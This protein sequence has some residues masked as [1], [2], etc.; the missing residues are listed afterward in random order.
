MGTT[1]LGWETC[2]ELERETGEGE[3]GQPELCMKVPQGNWLCNLI[4]FFKK[5]F[6]EPGVEAHASDSCIWE[7]GLRE[8]GIHYPLTQFEASW[9]YLRPSIKTKSANKKCC[10]LD[11]KA[12][13]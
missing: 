12:A 13:T 7:A 1:E 9:G 10:Y 3:T 2:V 11:E 5:A 8:S 6:I 4:F